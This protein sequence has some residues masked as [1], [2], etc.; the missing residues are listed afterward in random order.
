MSS[1]LSRST[2]IFLISLSEINMNKEEEDVDDLVVVLL[3]V[4][5]REGA[6]L[7]NISSLY[8]SINCLYSVELTKKGGS[9]LLSYPSSNMKLES[10]SVIVSTVGLGGMLII[11]FVGLVW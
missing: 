8:L 4:V 1:F 9:P 5:C 3:V 6:L 7:P 2:F 10:S 11:L